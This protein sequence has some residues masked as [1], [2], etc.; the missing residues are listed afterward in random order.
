MPVA[1][2]MTTHDRGFARASAGRVLDLVRDVEAW[3]T[4]LSHYRWVRMLEHDPDGGGV[5][6]M[7]ADRPFGSLRWPTFWRSL[8]EVDR[9][10]CAVRFRHIAG[11]TEG[12]EVEWG[13][14]PVEGGTRITLVHQWDGP[15]WPLIGSVAARAVI[16]PVFVHGI[17]GRTLAGLVRVAER[18]S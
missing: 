5:V 11:V 16:G 13:L 6:E 12:M 10:R 18:A 3:P 17:A 2:R 14:E 9:T 4:H 15:A 7:A 8:M 1:R